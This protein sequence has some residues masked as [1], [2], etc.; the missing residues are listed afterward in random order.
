MK[1]LILAFQFLTVFP[2]DWARS[3]ASES[4][5]GEEVSLPDFASAMAYFPVV[6]AV[7]GIIL[8]V[9]F[10]I[11]STYLPL[12]VAS[13]LVLAVLTLTNYG[14][15][16]DGFADTLDGLAGGKSKEDCLRIMRDGNIGPI[17][18]TGLVVFLIMEYASLASLSKAGFYSAI[19]LFPVVARWA[20]VPMSFLSNYAREGD[21]LGRSF[22]KVSPKTLI[23]ATIITAV[24]ALLLLGARGLIMLAFVALT[25]YITSLY[26]KKK[27]GGV[28]GDIFGFQSE[29]AGLIFMLLALISI[30]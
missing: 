7:Q 24:P 13:A 16:L 27:L 1:N 25:I 28:T 5:T 14:F 26:F 3:F 18:V 11:F 17:G 23:T 12:S 15:H 19:F 9:A 29:I 6:G 10:K 30:N 22:S 20:M 21:G 8:V 2:L 4:E